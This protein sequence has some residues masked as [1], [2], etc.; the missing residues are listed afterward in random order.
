MFIG[1]SERENGFV[2]VASVYFMTLKPTLR[3]NKRYVAFRV[4][5]ANGKMNEIEAKKIVYSGLLNF[6]GELGVARARAKFLEFDGE[7]QVGVLQCVRE[8]VERVK[9]ALALIGEA[10]GVKA[11]VEVVRVSG[12]IGRLKERLGLPTQHVF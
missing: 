12:L 5:W 6:L 10:N 1:V 9:A 8:E 2:F 11:R 4:S 7:G 3:E